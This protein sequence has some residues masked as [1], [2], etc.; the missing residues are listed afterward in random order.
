MSETVEA[1]TTTPAPSEAPRE[2]GL[3]S[4]TLR[5]AEENDISFVFNSWLRSYQSSDFAKGIPPKL[6]FPHHHQIIERILQRGGKL[7]IA[8]L[9]DEPSAILGWLCIEGK[10]LHYVYV[11]KPYRQLGIATKLIDGN[12]F[13]VY[14]HQTYA[15]G[16]LKKPLGPAAYDPYMI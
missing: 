15:T 14:T 11:K 5:P 8:C 6:Y 10:V 4:V 13:V 1:L 9:Q 2:L 3:H 12:R 16:F 7:T